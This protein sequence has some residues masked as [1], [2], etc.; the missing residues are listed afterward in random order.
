MKYKTFRALLIGAAVLAGGGALAGAYAAC[1]GGDA[2]T[3]S[4]TAR[5]ERPASTPSPPLTTKSKPTD[6][7][8]PNATSPAAELGA[9]RM[10]LSTRDTAILDRVRQ[11]VS[12]DKVKDAIKGASYKVNLYNEGG[13]IRAK[14]DLDRDEKWDEKWSFEGTSPDQGAKRQI[15]TKDDEVYDLEYRLDGGEWRKK[16][17]K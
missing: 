10:P 6:A 14:V 1:R 11:G 9:A 17:S 13:Q 2:T 8:S 7:P 3:G 4:A 16:E 12:G 5:A 15:S